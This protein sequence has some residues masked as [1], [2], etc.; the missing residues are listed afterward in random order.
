MVVPPHIDQ[1]TNYPIM[2]HYNLVDNGDISDVPPKVFGYFNER[3]QGQLVTPAFLVQITGSP[4]L[5]LERYDIYVMGKKNGGAKNNPPAYMTKLRIVSKSSERNS[6]QGQLGVRF[7]QGFGYINNDS[8]SDLKVMRPT[9]I[10]RLVTQDTSQFKLRAVIHV[11]GHVLAF[12]HAEAFIRIPLMDDRVLAKFENPINAKKRGA[13]AR[14]QEALKEWAHINRKAMQ[15]ENK[16]AVLRML[17][18]YKKN[19]RDTDFFGE[20]MLDILA[21]GLQLRDEFCSNAN[22]ETLFGDFLERVNSDN[23]ENKEN[24]KRSI[25]NEEDPDLEAKKRHALRKTQNL[26]N[27]DL[28][29]TSASSIKW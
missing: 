23:K 22:M 19:L 2:H 28:R 5:D 16:K 29:K 13:Y 4:V 17:V 21:I 1:F 24:K 7:I 6:T 12:S 11:N 3:G 25:D 18:V 10:S 9:N 27:T 26:N 14:K 8:N 15:E 20:F